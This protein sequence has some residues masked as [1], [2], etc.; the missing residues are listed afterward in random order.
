M[1]AVWGSF[2]TKDC[3]V[4]QLKREHE[5]EQRGNLPRMPDL[6]PGLNQSLK[7]CGTPKI[8]LSHEA[9]GMLTSRQPRMDS[10]MTRLGCIQVA[11]FRGRMLGSTMLLLRF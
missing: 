3:S 4:L 7:T 9:R 11:T 5:R 8:K 6:F 1:R 2:T 10:Q